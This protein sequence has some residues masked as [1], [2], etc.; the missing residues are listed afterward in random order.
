MNKPRS[1]ALWFFLAALIAIIGIGTY[2]S[3]THQES[4][5]DT[6]SS[7]ENASGSPQ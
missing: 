6:T 7:P 3:A 4:R 5:P 1:V 2:R